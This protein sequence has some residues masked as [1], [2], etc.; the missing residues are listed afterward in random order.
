[1]S[2][3]NDFT[4]ALIAADTKAAVAVV[5]SD[6]VSH[7]CGYKVAEVTF[8]GTVMTV[9]GVVRNS[10]TLDDENVIVLQADLVS[11]E[12]LIGRSLTCG[13]SRVDLEIIRNI[14]G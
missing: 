3:S 6:M 4:N 5:L 14:V 11:G 2:R 7:Y 1:M 8:A 13:L 12:D 9:I 10:D